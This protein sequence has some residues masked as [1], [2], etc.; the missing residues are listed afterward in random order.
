MCPSKSEYAT[1]VETRP[2]S[3]LKKISP[4]FLNA[5]TEAVPRRI[6]HILLNQDIGLVRVLKEQNPILG[7][8]YDGL[9][10]YLLFLALDQCGYRVD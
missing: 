2:P 1:I 9:P 6:L 5:I 4:P 10:E 8:P 7:G 3:P